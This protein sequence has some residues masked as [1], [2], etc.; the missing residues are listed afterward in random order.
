MKAKIIKA[1]EAEIDRRGLKFSIREVAKLLGISTK[2]VYQHFES[3]EQIIGCIIERSISGMKAAEQEV[4]HDSSLSIRQKLQKALTILPPGLVLHNIHVLEELKQ[5]YPSHW[6]D[7]DQY[8]NKG[9][10][11]IRLLVAAGIQAG[12]LR[13][14]DFELFIQVYVGAFYRIMEQH[15]LA[16]EGLS[17]EKALQSMV[18]LL[19]VGIYMKESE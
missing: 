7:V 2:T 4:M 19:L 6:E 15:D 17:L 16:R 11:N 8:L 14:F 13:E 5:L 9:W 3:K 1:S 18:D 12:E 10:V